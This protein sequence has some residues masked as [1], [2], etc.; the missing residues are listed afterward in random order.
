ME[1][2]ETITVGNVS[3]TFVTIGVGLMLDYFDDKTS[4]PG[5]VSEHF[6]MIDAD[7]MF[8]VS[9]E[10]FFLVGPS[11]IQ[12]KGF[13]MIDDAYEYLEMYGVTSNDKEEN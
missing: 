1:S 5:T 6:R 12:Y 11:K 3:K 13:T 4:T 7:G 2:K 9:V 10:S 8:I